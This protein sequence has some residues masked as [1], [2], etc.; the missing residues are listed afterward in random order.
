[1]LSSS[2]CHSRG[3]SPRIIKATSISWNQS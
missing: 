2:P 1:M 3:C